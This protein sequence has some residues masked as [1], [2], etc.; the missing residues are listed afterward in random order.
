MPAHVGGVSKSHLAKL[1]RT[2]A[3]TEPSAPNIK[4]ISVGV[5]NAHNQNFSRPRGLS[6]YSMRGPNLSPSALPW[7]GRAE[8]VGGST[9]YSPGLHPQLSRQ[10][11]GLGPTP[12]LRSKCRPC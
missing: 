12:P 5:S 1:K 7:Q 2:V 11:P 4:P 10:H 6:P 3:T 9:H 8:G